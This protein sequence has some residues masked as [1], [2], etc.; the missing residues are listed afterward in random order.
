MVYPVTCHGNVLGSL[1]QEDLGVWGVNL[2]DVDF[3]LLT[4]WKVAWTCAL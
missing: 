2:E 3:M 4:A 1:N